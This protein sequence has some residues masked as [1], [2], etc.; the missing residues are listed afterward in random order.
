MNAP[1]DIELVRRFNYWNW[2]GKPL[3]LQTVGLL[4]AWLLLAWYWGL[5]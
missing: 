1:N 2:Y 4:L 5:L 3:L